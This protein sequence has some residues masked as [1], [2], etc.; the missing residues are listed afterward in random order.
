[1]FGKCERVGKWLR[2]FRR[3]KVELKTSRGR[4]PFLFSSI[5]IKYFLGNG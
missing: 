4:L 5:N 3:V 2:Q 1:V